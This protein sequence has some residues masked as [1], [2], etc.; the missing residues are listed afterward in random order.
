MTFK[1]IVFTSSHGREL[2]TAIEEKTM[3]KVDVIWKSGD[4][5]IGV[6]RS[7]KSHESIETKTIIIHIG[8]NDLVDKNGEQVRHQNRVIGDVT[9]MLKMA[10]NLFP[11]SQIVYS[12]ILPRCDTRK[13]LA[14]PYLKKTRYINSCLL[15]V[16]RQNGWGIIPHKAFWMSRRAATPGY[17]RED[18]LHMNARGRAAFVR[19]ILSGLDS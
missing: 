9:K 12:E 8:H 10:E 4:G 1:L 14:Q 16:C 17:F 5:C 6:Q 13:W 2:K 15:K 3:D 18:G 7:L 11:S 19:E